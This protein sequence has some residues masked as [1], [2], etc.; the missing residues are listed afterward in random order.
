[1]DSSLDY[2]LRRKPLV[3]A[4][5]GVRELWVVDAKRRLVYRHDGVTADGYAQVDLVDAATRIVPRHAPEAFALSLD[6][7]EDI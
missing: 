6:M 4:S 7:L 3:Y 1:M 2:D 5:F